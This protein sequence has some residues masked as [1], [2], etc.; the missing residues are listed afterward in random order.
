MILSSL[1]LVVVGVASPGPAESAPQS[2]PG[3]AR[4]AVTGRVIVAG[5]ENPVEGAQ[6]RANGSEGTTGADGRF[7]LVLSPGTWSI[8][9]V[10]E[11]FLSDTITIT[12]GTRP[13]DGLQVLLADA[14]F[15]ETVVVSAQGKAP[16][17][18]SPVPVKPD[19]V[20]AQ[21]G[22]ADNVFRTLQTLAGVT[23]AND[24]ESRISVRGGGPDQNLTIMDG[25]EIH[26]PY[27][28]FGLTSAFNP[29]IVADFELATGAFS[30]RH[31]DRLSSLLT[32]EN[33]LGTDEKSLGGSAAMSITDANVVFE[34]KL[35][36]QRRGSWLFSGRRTYY[37]LVA[38]RIVDQDLP[39]FADVQT[40]VARELGPGQRLSFTGLLSRESTDAGFDDESSG[41]NGAILTNAKNDLL[42]ISLDTPLGAGGSSRT[43]ASYY[44]FVDAL[45]FGG[46]LQSDNRVSNTGD[47]ETRLGFVEVIFRRQVEVCDLS[48]RQDFLKAA[49]ARH[50]LDFGAELHSLKT[51]WGWEIPGERNPNVGNGSSVQGGNG[52]PDL[53][54]SRVDSTRLGAWLA[55]RFQA[56]SRFV[57]EPGVRLDYST[58]NENASLSPRLAAMLEVSP[59]T[60]LRAAVGLHSQSPGYEKL[61]QADYFVDLSQGPDL[62]SERSTH[63]ILGIERELALGVTARLEGF[64]KDFSDLIVGR[65]ETEEERLARVA[66]YDF[67]PELQS[68]IPTEPEITS[69]PSNGSKGTAYGFEIYLAKR[70]IFVSSR[71]AGWLAYTF[72]NAERDAY[73]RVYPFD[74]D[75]RHSL[76]AV[77]SYRIGDKFDWAVTA[78][79]ASGFP[80]T[81][82]R[83]VRVV[84]ALDPADP[85]RLIP[86]TDEDGNLVW[87][88]DP[89][90]A[91]NLNSDRF[92]D[93]ARV[94]TRI[95]F[96]PKGLTGR[97]E[98]YL[99]AINLFNRSNAAEADY[100]IRFD[101][102]TGEPFLTQGLNESG[103]PFLPTFGIRFRF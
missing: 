40:K 56:T 20:L 38:E 78:R 99:E 63:F 83:G 80:F 12:V 9:V 94:D 36:G 29:Q 31:G 33:R 43:V 34:G 59:K 86:S 74:Y 95:T 79:F 11:G 68:S 85:E 75:R 13:I 21:A 27:R 49:G 44:R 30:V 3:D 14:R 76:N 19:A 66:P 72:T 53:L 55:D 77:G 100:D 98:F 22:V 90:G 47:P 73:D 42:A 24:F 65:L 37:D 58:I 91:A 1:L 54:D 88:I 70:P 26:N 67:P 81:P 84:A 41:E 8:D 87:S 7:R 82:A 25:V 18:P 6:L 92:P 52:L 61:F 93:Y 101:A 96:R 62:E 50:L 103:I 45:D 5:S 10:A 89:G 48:L 69:F 39:S 46:S 60:R 97:W 102:V 32:V 23:A 4:V 35:P 28:L 15:S 51:R 71:L 17:G 16:A 57:I 2:A 64:Y